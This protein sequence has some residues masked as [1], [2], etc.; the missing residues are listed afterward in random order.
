MARFQVFH[1][2]ALHGLCP[3]CWRF[4][5]SSCFIWHCRST[6]TPPQIP[7]TRAAETFG[8]AEGVCHTGVVQSVGRGRSVVGRLVWWAAHHEPAAWRG[9][10]LQPSHPRMRDRGNRMHNR[11]DHW[12]CGGVAVPIPPIDGPENPKMKTA[13]Q[14]NRYAAA[15]TK[16]AT[17]SK[18]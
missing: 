3:W 10:V 16:S 11:Y 15:A 14:R 13:T 7:K 18:V 17:Q 5:D 9:N 8:P 6:N 12:H 4:W 2:S 1:W